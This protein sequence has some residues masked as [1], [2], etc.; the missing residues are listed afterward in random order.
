LAGRINVANRSGAS[1]MDIAT[2][3]AADTLELTIEKMVYGGDGL[4]RT[5]EGAMLVAGALPGE[6]VAVR[7]ETR[8]R[9]VRRGELVQVLDASPDRVLPPCPYYGRCGGCQYQHISYERQAQVKREILVECL[10]RIGKI[11]LEAPIQFIAGE[12]W[13]YR[14][15]ARLQVEQQASMFRVGYFELFS[16][17][18]CPVDHCPISSPAI[19]EVLGKLAQGV[20]ASCFPDGKAELELFAS[21]SDRTLLA[22]IYSAAAAPRQ[23]GEKLMGAIPA[24]ESVCWRDETARREKTWGSG[25]ISYHVGEFHYRVGHD[26]FFQTNRFLTGEMIRCA[27]GDL[28]GTRALDLYAGVGFFT[29]PLARHFQKVMAVEGHP[30]SA[31]DLASNIGVV[32]GQARSRQESVER[33]LAEESGPWDLIVVDPPRNGLPR[34]VREHVRRL[35]PARLVYVSCDPATLARDLGALTPSGYKIESIHFI[36]QFPQTFHLETV[37]HLVSSG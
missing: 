6:R 18:L 27:M 24:L 31:R 32:Y 26:S 37:V 16:R 19:G 25:G 35:R 29:I 17:R 10:E 23:F 2:N 20:G 5:S 1:V 9:G 7:P 15:R 3:S 22:T 34:A 13:H 36:D 21:D 30:A 8:R 12:P 11:R 28:Q 14:N 33:F 4:A